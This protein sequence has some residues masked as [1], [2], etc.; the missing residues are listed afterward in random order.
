M[1]TIYFHQGG[2]Y[3]LPHYIGAI[4]ELLRENKNT[5]FI[6]YGNSAGSSLALVCYLVLNDH[7][8]I[9]QMKMLCHSVFSK[10]RPISRILTPIVCDLIDSSI[11]YWPAD[12]AQRISGVINMGVSTRNGHKWMNEFATNRDIYNTLLCSGTIAGCSNYESTIDGEVC[13]DGG[14]TF[15]PDYLPKDTILIASDVKLP[16]S[17]TCPPS[18][19]TPFLEENGRR[20][21]K[22]GLEQPMITHKYPH[23]MKWWICLHEYTEKDPK[24]KGHIRK[25]CRRKKQ[26]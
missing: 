18:F 14:Y 22:Y 6:Y 26:K 19:I 3:A 16:L 20:N 25:M 5:E 23:L 13:L 12:F 17:L 2:F 7:V 1:K 24:W 9:E 4:R 11:P 15:T 10:P 8:S 21:V